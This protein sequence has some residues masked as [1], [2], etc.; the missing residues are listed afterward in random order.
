MDFCDLWPPSRTV[1]N[2]LIFKSIPCILWLSLVIPMR[3]QF[4]TPYLAS[5]VDL[6]AKDTQCLQASIFLFNHLKNNEYFGPMYHGYTL[7]GTQGRFALAYTPKSYVRMEAGCFLQQDMGTS[8]FSVF[9]PFFSMK[10]KKGNHEVIFGNLE[11]SVLHEMIAPLWDPERSMTRPFENGLQYLVKGRR[12]HSDAWIDWVKKED[13]DLHIQELIEAG[14][15]IKFFLI[16]KDKKHLSLV[17]QGAVWHLGGQL[18]R[19]AAPIETIGNGAA[20]L[21]WER[22]DSNSTLRKLG[23]ES[24]AVKYIHNAHTELRRFPEG[25]GF[26]SGIFGELKQ[27]F[28]LQAHYFFGYHFITGTGGPLF[29]SVSSHY[30]T[31]YENYRELILASVGYRNELFPGFWIDVRVEPYYDLGGGFLEY[32]YSGFITFK[33][34]FHLKKLK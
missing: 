13:T 14:F 24:F 34:N 12:F 32:S 6:Q 19:S 16:K 18:N 17:S 7:F 30:T 10:L 28:F 4:S 8:S 2:F 23:L 27:G 5:S 33:H 20:G 26:Y 9:R 3:A 1:L 15:N 22:V 11:G 25:H 29:Q 21:R 31:Y